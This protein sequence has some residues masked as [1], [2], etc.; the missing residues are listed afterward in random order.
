[1]NAPNI[2]RGHHLTRKRTF[3]GAVGGFFARAAGA[4]AARGF[5]IMLDNID[6]GLGQGS[7]ELRLPD[8]AV[9]F[10]GGRAAGPAA[11]A[12]IQHWNALVRLARH[13]SVGCYEGWIAGDWDSSDPVALFELF[14]CNRKSLGNAARASGMARMAGKVAHQFKRN[15]KTGAKRNI[16]FHYDLGNDFY[17]TW[18]DT[19]MTYSSA[20]FASDD[21]TLEEAQARKIDAI[22]DRLNL[23][24]GSRLLEIGCGWGSLAEAALRRQHLEYHGITL[25]AEQKVYVEKRLRTADLANKAK[26]TLTDYRDVTDIYDAIASV[27]MVEAV[28]QDY[29]PAYLDSIARSLNSGGRAAIQYIAIDDDIFEAYSRSA[30]FIQRYIFPGGML[31]SQSRFRALAEARGLRW[32]DQADF[33]L[34]YAKTLHMWRDRFD[35]AVEQGKLPSG[36]DEKFVSLWRFYLMYCEGGFRG[37]GINVAQVTLVKN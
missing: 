17:S 8:G 13:G 16:E 2:S 9:R 32:E 28:G 18:L 23:I 35:A 27:E 26:V 3:F 31:L 1:M 12:E 33:G 5:H 36:F 25:S 21:E 6:R 22:L 34:D 29:W 20:I 37:G 7:V 19:S 24:D 11:Q 30:D 4:V 15:S 14:V 10:L